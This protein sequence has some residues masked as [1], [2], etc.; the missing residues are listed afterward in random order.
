MDQLY[1]RYA[2]PFSFIN[3]MIHTGR[4][5]EFVESFVDTVNKEKEEEHTWNFYLHKVFEGSYK[6]FKES[7]DVNTRHQEMSDDDIEA[8]LQHTM[9]IM[10]NF[11]PEQGGE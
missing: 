11:N 6:E 2:D 3:G 5:S 9:H 1:T 10:N 4:F 7:L 8:A